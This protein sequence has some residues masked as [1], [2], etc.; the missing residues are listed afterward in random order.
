MLKQCLDFVAFFDATKN[1][2]YTEFFIWIRF[3]LLFLTSW[4]LPKRLV[5]FYIW[6]QKNICLHRKLHITHKLQLKPKQKLK[7]KTVCS[8]SLL[9][10][11]K[12]WWNESAATINLNVLKLS[13]EDYLENW[14]ILLLNGI[15]NIHLLL[16]NPLFFHTLF[17]FF[18]AADITNEKS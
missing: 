18:H 5:S 11:E 8:E 1:G 3:K 4:K 17:K 13:L 15:W 7:S 6:L 2:R 10:F 16:G 9:I 14:K 12:R